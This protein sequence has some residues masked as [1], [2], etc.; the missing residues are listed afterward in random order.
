MNMFSQDTQT[1][2]MICMIQ[3]IWYD[4]K[5][6][7][8]CLLIQVWVVKIVTCLWVQW[9][10]WTSFC[11]HSVTFSEKSTCN[12]TA[13]ESHSSIILRKCTCCFLLTNLCSEK[14]GSWF[15]RSSKTALILAIMVTFSALLPCVCYCWYFKR[16]S[17]S[18]VCGLKSSWKF[19]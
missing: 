15:L 7:F 19:L 4:C 3:I 9:A 2:W 18:S 1:V 14:L 17:P 8:T 13:V 10:D 11:S 6:F 12:T 5:T 16:I